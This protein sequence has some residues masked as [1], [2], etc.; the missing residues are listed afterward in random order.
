M[1]IPVSQ[2][3]IERVHQ[4]RQSGKSARAWCV[5]QRVAYHRL[6]YWKDRLFLEERFVE[7]ADRSDGDAGISI[8][9]KSLQIQLS[10]QFDPPTLQRLL[11]LLRSC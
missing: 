9:L 4:W 8:D 6:L 10:R 2:E 5:E 7:V 11:Q 1:A 3:W